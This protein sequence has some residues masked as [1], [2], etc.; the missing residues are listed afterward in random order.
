MVSITNKLLNSPI[1][2]AFFTSLVRPSVTNTNRKKDKGPP[3]P[4]APINLEI[5]S[6]TLINN[7][8]HKAIEDA[9]LHPL[10]PFLPKPHY[11]EQ[12]PQVV[13][14][15]I[16]ICLLIIYLHHKTI[17]FI[18]SPCFNLILKIVPTIV[19]TVINFTLIP[20]QIFFIMR[21]CIST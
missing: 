2:T 18:P 6:C 15:H 19:A 12:K 14:I 8:M 17:S 21:I 10:F 3:L 16:I 11:V 5:Q 20:L 7:N 13:P 4:Q 1:S 9:C